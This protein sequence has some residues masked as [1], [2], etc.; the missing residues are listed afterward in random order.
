MV[1]NYILGNTTYSAADMSV[2]YQLPQHISMGI[3]EVFISV[4]SLE[5]AYMA[6]PESAQSLV[7]SLRFCSAGLSSFLGSAYVSV[8]ENIYE[9]FT[10]TN[11]EVNK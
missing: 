6:A 8:Y 4:A 1:L 5:F 10:A 11:F 7:M 2:F 9:N 3:G